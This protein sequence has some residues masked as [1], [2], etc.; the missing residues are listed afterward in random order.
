MFIQTYIPHIHIF[1]ALSTKKEINN[2]KKKK[3]SAIP[4]PIIIHR[5]FYFHRLQGEK[6]KKEKAL[7]FVP[8]ALG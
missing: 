3:K 4:P 1:F 8:K 6:N 2:F 5:L 7:L